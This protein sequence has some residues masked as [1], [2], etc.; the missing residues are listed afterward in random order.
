MPLYKP[1]AL[2]LRGGSL[3]AGNSSQV[4]QFFDRLIVV[5]TTARQTLYANLITSLVAAGVWA[6]LD[7]LIICATANQP[8]SFVNLISNNFMPAFNNAGAL[9][10]FTADQGWTGAAATINLYS[11]F[12]P[13]TAGGNYAQN[14]AMVSAWA[15]STAQVNF[16]LWTATNIEGWPKDSNSYMRGEANSPTEQFVTVS[17]DSS[18]FYLTNRTVSNA[19]TLS[20]NDTLVGSFTDASAALPNSAIAFGEN[21]QLAAY[22][23]G[24]ALTG[25][26]QTALYTILQTYLHAVG[27]V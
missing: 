17:T 16:P 11:N 19:W 12:N 7:V 18:G 6:L 13:S 1:A 23:I 9:P 2:L 21:Q 5:P 20:R 25:P 8:T 4:E 10:T 15:L 24:A 27:A 26:Q 22:A 3:Y 14:S